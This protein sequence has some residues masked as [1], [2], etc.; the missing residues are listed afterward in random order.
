MK[1]R[2]GW[3]VM[4]I[5]VTGACDVQDDDDSAG[6]E[7]SVTQTDWSGGG[8]G[9]GPVTEWGTD[10]QA[11][12][13]LAW[14]SIAG[15]LALASSPRDTPAAHT[16]SEDYGTPYGIHGID[17]DLDGDTDVI[18]AAHDSGDIIVWLNDGASP[19]GWDERVIDDAF[20]RASA[21]HSADLDGDGLPDVLAASDNSSGGVTWWRNDGGDPAGWAR[22][23]IDD[24]FAVACGV[25]TAD[26]DGDGHLDVL[27][28][29]WTGQEVAWWRNDGGAPIGWTKHVVEDDYNGSHEVFGADLDGDGDVD[30]TGVAGMD[31]EVSWWRNDGNDD[32]VEQTI[33]GNFGGARSAYV[34]DMDEDGRMDVVATGFDDGMAW[35]RNGGGDPIEWTRHDID[36]EFAAGHRVEVM[37]LDGDGDLDVLGAAYSPDEIIWWRNEG[38]PEPAWT[39]FPIDGNTSFGM[40]THFADVDGDGD[41]DVLGT[42]REPDGYYWW[43]IVEFEP[44][45]TLDSVTLDLGGASNAWLEWDALLPDG[46]GLSCQV[47][48][49]AKPDAL[50]SWVDVP[51][52]GESF[53]FPDRYMQVRIVM[54]STATA[55]SPVVHE[56]TL[57]W[58][59]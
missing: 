36:A 11:V 57:T 33:D 40:F 43:E 28:G 8:E 14:R 44:A 26:V 51:G 13:G 6:A 41:L 2:W 42:L 47:R 52:A 37:D 22:Q 16:I 54:E 53:E 27:S 39:P 25:H 12:D 3:L 45:G 19:P 17:L 15:Q 50:G 30:L 38:G 48:G 56:L 20:W 23:D 4:V 1:M 10:F 29:S 5:L 32:W 31:G 59:E 34:A 49:G 58:N 24:D 35:W 7:H 55:V 9:A 21:V 18:G 46:T